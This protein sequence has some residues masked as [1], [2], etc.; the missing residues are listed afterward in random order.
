MLKLDVQG[1]EE[2]VLRSCGRFI[3]NLKLV[4]MELSGVPLYQGQ[5][6]LGK[7]TAMMEDLG[8]ALIY[9][10]NSFGHRSVYIDYDFIFCRR[11]EL[12]SM[13]F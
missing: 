6:S 4:Q 10:C 1:F 12:E 5:E 11:D 2:R 3:P 9:T 8:F 13:E 7:M